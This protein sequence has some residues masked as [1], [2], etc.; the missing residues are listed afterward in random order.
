MISKHIT[1]EYLCIRIREEEGKV[2]S[3]KDKKPKKLNF[4]IKKETST[5]YKTESMNSDKKRPLSKISTES[6]TK[7]AT[8]SDVPWYA[9]KRRIISE[10]NTG[11]ESI[12]T[13]HHRIP[14]FKQQLKWT[15]TYKSSAA[16]NMSIRD[17]ESKISVGVYEKLMKQS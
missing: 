1:Y 7:Y 11:E 6:F 10:I 9:R 2:T 5:R 3:S 13:F 16:D 4:L 17:S 14:K 8:P 12:Q 15:N